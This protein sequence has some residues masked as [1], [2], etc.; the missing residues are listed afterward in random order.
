MEK[1]GITSLDEK[2]EGL[3]MS[4]GG[5]TN[6]ISPLEMAGAYATIANNG[7]YIE[8]TF[9]TKVTDIN[10][11]TVLTPNQTTTRVMSEQNAYIAKEL[12]TQP[13]VGSQGTAT[14]CSIKGI[15][16]AA[17]TG[18]TNDNYDRWLCGFTNY[19][20]ATTWYGFDENE[21]IRYSGRNPAGQ[22]WDNVMTAIHQDLP[23][24]RFE[25]PSGIVTAEVCS[26]TGQLAT[27]K[28]GSTYTEIFVEGNLPEE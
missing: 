18:T 19:Y 26:A 6:G 11:E 25:E 16:V 14:Y 12:L 7:V 3:A 10:G 28:C 5:L 17:K 20:T 8:P 27:S 1:M 2:R 22:L 21:E 15:D 24:S 4:I 23:S 13:V 9:Y